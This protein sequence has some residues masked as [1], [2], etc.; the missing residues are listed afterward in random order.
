MWL[1][2]GWF[3]PYPEEALEPS[4]GLVPLMVIIQESNKKL[5]PV[6]D[7]RELNKYIDTFIASAV[8]CADNLRKSTSNYSFTCG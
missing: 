4:K 3:I 7:Y 6:M 2:N 1:D 5:H 8:V